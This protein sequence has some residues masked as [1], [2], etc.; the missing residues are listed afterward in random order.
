M[1]QAETPGRELTTADFMELERRDEEQILAEIQG[2]VIEEMVYSFP[3]G[4]RTVTGLSW[5]GIKEIARRYGKIDVDP[6]RLEDTGDAWIVVVKARDL[7][8]GTGILGVSTQP[9]SMKARGETVEDPFA[10]QKATSKAQRNA[11]RSLIPE[12]FLKAVITE[13]LKAK[14][15]PG[16]RRE[17]QQ[18]PRKRVEAQARVQPKRQPPVAMEESGGSAEDDPDVQAVLG[19]LKDAGL[20]VGS[21][22]MVKKDGK[23]WVQHP[24]TWSQDRW[25]DYNDVIHG[26]LEGTYSRDLGAWAVTP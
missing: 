22:I 15:N 13:W 7:E 23:V 14:K 17:P 21:L 26:G 16:A 25:N 11:I 19:Q 12:T 5:V 18:E 6:V 10:L 24:E 4:G 20:S 1:T 8:R 9:K 3:S 2:Q